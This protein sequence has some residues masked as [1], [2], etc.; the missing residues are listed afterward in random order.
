MPLEQHRGQ[1]EIYAWVDKA[2]SSLT[3]STELLLSQQTPQDLRGLREAIQPTRFLYKSRQ[4]RLDWVRKQKGKHTIDKCVIGFSQKKAENEMYVPGA[5]LSRQTLRYVC[6][7]SKY[8]STER[9]REREKE[10]EC[11]LCFGTYL[12]ISEACSR[13]KEEANDG[14]VYLLIISK[15]S[16]LSLCV[17]VCA[18]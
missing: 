13:D 17:S 5:E 16:R 8:T 14:N 9:D 6:F 12:I 18:R 4:I 1:C 10:R 11:T 2:P 15:M 3:G 7:P